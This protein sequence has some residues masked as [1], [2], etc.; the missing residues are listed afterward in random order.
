M[1]NSEACLL[2]SNILLRMSKSDDPQ[3]R[4]IETALHVLTARCAPLL[5]FADVRRVLERCDTT[6][7]PERLRVERARDGSP[8][9][10]D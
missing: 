5:H 1:G 8:C 9:P 4:T 7:W 2:D 3:R 6:G 10:R